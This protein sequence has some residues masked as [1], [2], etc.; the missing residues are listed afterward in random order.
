MKD[1]LKVGDIVIVHNPLL[2]SG[3]NRYSVTKIEGNRATTDFRVFD[4]KI[5]HTNEVYEYGK[6]PNEYNN[7]YTVERKAE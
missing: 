6:R 5:Y 3:E 4:V 2:L 7:Y 1:K